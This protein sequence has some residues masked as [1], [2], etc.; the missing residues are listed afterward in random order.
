MKIQNDINPNYSLIK[1]SIDT[2]E[3]VELKHIS[4]KLDETQYG[5]IYPPVHQGI[6]DYVLKNNG[7][8]RKCTEVLAQDTILQDYVFKDKNGDNVYEEDLFEFWNKKNKHN[9]SLAVT[10][11]YQYGFGVCEI[12]LLDGKPVELVQIPA[13]TMVIQKDNDTYYAVQMEFNAEIK[14]FLIYDLMDTYSEE[15]KQQYGVVLWLGGGTTHRFYDIPVWY[16]ET[17][18]ILAK[19]NMNILTAQQVNDGN[20]ISG[21]LNISGAPQRPNRE[22]G[23]TVEEQLRQQMRNA[24][25]G[26]LVSYLE[27]PNKD[28]P[29]NFEFIR[30]SNDNWTYLENFS[31]SVDDAV[32]SMYSIP[33][34]RLMI[35]D[36]TESMN[37]NKSDTIWQIYAISL[38]Y[39]QFPNELIIQEFNKFYFDCDFEVDMQI[40]IF[41]DKKQIELS[42]VKD[43]FNSGLLTLGQAVVKVAEFYPELS[44]DLNFDMEDFVMQGRYYNGKALGFG[45]DMGSDDA[46]LLDAPV[47]NSQVGDILKYFAE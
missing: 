9:L 21:I 39:E 2:T 25:T 37:S 14:K 41:S 8:L 3:G 44:I 47:T 1:S 24:G 17:D 27:T 40:P 46:S 16:P 28:F 20:N 32:M 43:L 11:R 23:L 19:I 38:N 22:T 7:K 26:I 6:T 42:T 36:T 29:L 13:K 45:D 30:I 34:V 18:S 10:E 4:T 35:D 12:I 5:Y 31:K 33:K 15:D